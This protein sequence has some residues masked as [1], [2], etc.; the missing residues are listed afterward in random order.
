MGAVKMLQSA[1]R[2]AQAEHVTSLGLD[3]EVLG[4]LIGIRGSN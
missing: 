1:E 3:P 2:N 4:Q